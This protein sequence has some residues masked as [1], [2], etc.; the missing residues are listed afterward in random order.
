MRA[1]LTVTGAPRSLL[2]EAEA[3]LLRVAQEALANVRKHAHA[4]QVELTLSYIGDT[5]IL[6]VQDDGVGLD[7]RS[8]ADEL[9]GFGLHSMRERLARL[10]GSL[11]I[12]SAPGEGL[13]LAVTLP[14]AQA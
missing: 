12:E 13:T 6:D 2:P 9:S 10:G 7:A 3:T 1:N 11:A 8:P 4:S 5:L 14:T